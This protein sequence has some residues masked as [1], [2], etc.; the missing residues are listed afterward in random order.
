MKLIALCVLCAVVSTAL[1]MRK[2]GV[3]VKGK[4]RCGAE[5][6]RNV[7]VKIFD[8]DSGVDPDDLLDEGFTDNQGNFQ[9]D[10]S[11]REMTT[12][13]PVLKIYHDCDDGIKPCQRKIKFTVPDKYIHDGTVK[14]W[15]DIGEVNMEIE[16]QD[17]ERD[18]SH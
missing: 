4:L 16:F 14:K 5:P 9:L 6:L 1:A 8:E 17:E 2:Q 15:F 13:D 11:T 12:I 18:C 7:K 3:G 10:G